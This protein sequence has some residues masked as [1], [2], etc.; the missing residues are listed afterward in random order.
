M[1]NG[2]DQIYV[3]KQGELV[4]FPKAF[5]SQEKL[6]DV[7]QQIVAKV[8]RRVNEANPMADARLEDGSRV[9]IILPPM[10]RFLRSGDLQSILLICTN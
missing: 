9:N 7:I 8:N 6:E 3:E 1:V 4:R 10:V 2:Y 5:S